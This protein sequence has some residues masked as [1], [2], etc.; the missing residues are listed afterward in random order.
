MQ[1]DEVSI[2]VKCAA[3]YVISWRKPIVFTTNFEITDDGFL[4]R[5]EII[6]TDY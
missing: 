3:P 5:V 2:D 6:N 1:G 4:A